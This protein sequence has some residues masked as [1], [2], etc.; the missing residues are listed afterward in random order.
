RTCSPPFSC[1]RRSS[2]WRSTAA[3]R[4]RRRSASSHAMKIFD[5]PNF[6]FV[7][8]R[9]HALALSTVIVLA[10]AYIIGTRGLQT[11]VDF[12]GGTVVIL[13]FNETPD[14]GRITAALGGDAVVQQYGPAENRDVMIRVKRVGAEIGG[15][16]SREVGN[17][18][19]ALKTAN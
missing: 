15:D 17:I 11:G 4:R 13:K 12:E 8:W 2:S 3:R 1:R 5:N 19:A 7:R 16:L 6:N 9:W 18:I 10:G 14:L